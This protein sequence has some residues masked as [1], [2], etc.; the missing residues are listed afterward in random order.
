MTHEAGVDDG[1]LEIEEWEIAD[2]ELAAQGMIEAE[3]EQFWINMRS[4]EV[5]EQESLIAQVMEEHGCG[6]EEAL[7]ILHGLNGVTL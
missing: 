6:P 2:A 4:P 7:R 3:R 5:V 1:D